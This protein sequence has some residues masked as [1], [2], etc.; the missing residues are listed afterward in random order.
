MPLYALTTY[1]PTC[2]LGLITVFLLL[3]AHIPLQYLIGT[4]LVWSLMDGLGVAVGYHRVFSH[5]THQLPWWKEN[6][7]LFLGS[8]AG[9]GSPIVWVAIHRGYHH[10]FADT[11]KDPHSPI[12]GWLYALF[13]W[14]LNI[15]EGSVSVKYA[16]D[17]VRKSHFVWWHHHGWKVQWLVTAAAVF[18]DWRFGLAC[19]ALPSAMSLWNESIINI[20][21]HAWSP[22]AYRNF[23][24]KDQSYNHPW[25]GY[26]GW[27]HGWHNNHHAKPNEFNFR[28]RWWEIDPCVIFLPFL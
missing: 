2:L 21:G 16:V 8:M 4:L 23:D 24:S 13:G 3:T 5:R 18:L 15:V 25:F 19:V 26:F 20:F 1:L 11:K 27:G 10:A 22:G 12:H 9:H 7:L 14:T 28:Q 17:L 6:L